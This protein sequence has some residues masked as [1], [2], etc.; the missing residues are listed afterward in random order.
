MIG[1]LA[2]GSVDAVQQAIYGLSGAV[3]PSHELDVMQAPCG[4]H[5]VPARLAGDGL[6]EAVDAHQ[7]RAIATAGGDMADGFA[8][9]LL[10]LRPDQEPVRSH[11]GDT[12]ALVRQGPILVEG[13][14]SYPERKPKIGRP[15][16]TVNS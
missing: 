5:G 6:T 4:V 2:V 10:V 12:H 3:P 16:G 7:V 9:G 14:Y 11:R 1:R 15:A 8:F 13:P